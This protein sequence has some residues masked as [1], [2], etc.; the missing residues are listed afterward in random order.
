M[1]ILSII[2][3]DSHLD[4]RKWFKNRVL[5]TVAR[6]CN[7]LISRRQKSLPPTDCQIGLCSEDF[8]GDYV[9]VERLTITVPLGLESAI[10][11]RERRQRLAYRTLF[12]LSSNAPKKN[13]QH[14]TYKAFAE[15]GKVIKFLCRYLHS[16]ALRREIHEGLNVVEQWN[17]ATDFVFFCG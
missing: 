13:L 15:L 11:S 17:G 7:Y 3:I 9:D 14:P 2:R 4:Q 16:E 5:A 6:N 12:P 1:I 8:L 10:F